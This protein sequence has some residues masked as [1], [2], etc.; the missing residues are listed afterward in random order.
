MKEAERTPS[1][2]R[3]ARALGIRKAALKCVRGIGISKIMSEY[4]FAN[5]PA[6]RLRKNSRG[7]KE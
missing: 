4:P 7:D 3:F 6:I 1:P 2:K 5:E